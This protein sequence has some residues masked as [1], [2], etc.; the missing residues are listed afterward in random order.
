MG[1]TWK[2][3]YYLPPHQWS[4]SNIRGVA[5]VQ[6]HTRSEASFAF[7]K[8]YAGQFSTIERIEKFD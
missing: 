2:V 4:G 3:I 7:Q 8:Q 5:F 1:Y 6:A